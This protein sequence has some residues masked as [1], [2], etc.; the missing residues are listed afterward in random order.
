MKTR[1]TLAIILV[2]LIVA[3]SVATFVACN[4]EDN[5]VDVVIVD[6]APAL[7]V[8]NLMR[9]FKTYENYTIN[10]KVVGGADALSDAITNG[11]ADIAIAPT[12]LGAKF[13]N[14]GVDIKLASTNIQGLLYMVGKTEVA[15]LNELVGKVVYNIGRGQTPDLTFKYILQQKGIEYVDSETPVEGK[16][17]LHYVSSGGELIPL[18]KAGK[19]QYGILGEPAVTKAKVAAGV[20]EIFNIQALWNEVTNTNTNFPQASTFVLGDYNDAEHSELINAFIAKMEE[21]VTFMNSSADNLALAIDAVK[22]LY[23]D[24]ATANVNINNIGRCNLKVVKAQD[25]KASVT[26]YLTV[27]HGFNAKTIGGSVPGEAFFY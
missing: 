24:T 6:G 4:K 19:A 11:E 15:S 21:N 7:A 1:K 23:E 8:A 20:Q 18:L 26:A 22:A 10:Y 14:S 25:A 16:V 2:V 27:L 13:F 3:L 9:E 17:A 12:N 5:T